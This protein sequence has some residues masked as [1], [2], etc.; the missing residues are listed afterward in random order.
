[1]EKPQVGLALGSGGARGFAHLGVLKVLKEE[2]IPV[3]MIAGSSMG[4]LVG[5]F[6]AS[7]Q[8]A[9]ILAETD[10]RFFPFFIARIL[11]GIF[12]G[13][14]ALLLWKPLYEQHCCQE[15]TL[16]VLPAG[17]I[18]QPED[19]NSFFYVL[20]KYGP[21]VTLI[22]LFLYIAILSLRLLQSSRH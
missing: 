9:S 16:G 15:K 1:M 17:W 8:V 14:Y 3:H 4:A 10:I 2:G 13:F 11:Q 7:G 22:S 19:M 20:G 21:L 18:P 6:Y 5:C 12:A